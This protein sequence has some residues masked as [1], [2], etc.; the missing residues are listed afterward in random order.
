MPC[1]ATE[2]IEKKSLNKRFT[3]VPLN[4]TR[5]TLLNAQKQDAAVKATHNA[6]ALA[7]KLVDYDPEVKVAMQHA[8]GNTFICDDE[9]AA[10]KVMEDHTVRC[11]GVSLAGDDYNTNG[12][13]TGGSRNPNAML[14]KL[15]QLQKIEEQLEAAEVRSCLGD[16][17]IIGVLLRRI[18]NPA[19]WSPEAPC[20]AC[21]AVLPPTLL[22]WHCLPWAYK[23]NASVV[24]CSKC[25]AVNAG[26]FGQD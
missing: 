19:P 17:L 13:L 7:L 23:I 6:A 1:A 14:L 15:Q 4:K 3:I 24:S 16:R 8:F 12:T 21:L 20:T 10:R 5:P 26:G 18:P 25:A 2:L 22:A 9:H 11:R